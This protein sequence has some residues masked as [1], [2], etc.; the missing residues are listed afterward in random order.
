VSHTK[1]NTGT[2]SQ[3]S[4]SSLAGMSHRLKYESG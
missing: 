1:H 3:A 2:V 4:W